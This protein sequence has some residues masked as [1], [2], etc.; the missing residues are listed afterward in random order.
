M[1]MKMGMERGAGTQRCHQEALSIHRRQQR[2]ARILPRVAVLLRRSNG[3]VTSLSLFQLCEN[4]LERRETS[5][6]KCLL[7][8]TRRFFVSIFPLKAAL[9]VIFQ[10]SVFALFLQSRQFAYLS[11]LE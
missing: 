7:V 2:R 3:R 5:E 11:T 4:N 6:T 10:V 9:R 8:R 1:K